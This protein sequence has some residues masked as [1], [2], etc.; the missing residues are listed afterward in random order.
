[1]KEAQR[2]I[3]HG[4]GLLDVIRG[5]S[6][7]HGDI[8]HKL[9]YLLQALSQDIVLSNRVIDRRPDIVGVEKQLRNH[10]V[11][12]MSQRHPLR[13]L[14]ILGAIP[15]LHDHSVL[16]L[17]LVLETQHLL[18]LESDVAE[19]DAWLRL[20]RM[21]GDFLDHRLPCIE[22]HL[23]RV[24]KVGVSLAIVE[25]V[26]LHLLAQDALPIRIDVGGELISLF[27]L[28]DLLDNLEPKVNRVFLGLLPLVIDRPR[29][30]D[31]L[32]RCLV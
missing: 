11:V 27:A 15:H 17:H 24:V 28:I 18:I 22:E 31:I 25:H 4:V 12:A 21:E 1:M 16:D 19:S 14:G 32:N 30:R 20:W 13:A 23:E 29:P 26:H 7:Y 3:S 10:L 8:L 5:F 9:G 6:L 2:L